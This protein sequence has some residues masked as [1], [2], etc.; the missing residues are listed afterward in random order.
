ML[1]YTLVSVYTKKA[2]TPLRMI[3]HF[4]RQERMYWFM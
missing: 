2:V 3:Y 1:H 4:E